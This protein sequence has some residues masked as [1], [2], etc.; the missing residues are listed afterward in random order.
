MDYTTIANVKAALKIEAAGD[1]ALLSSLV[2]RASRA[3]DRLITQSDQPDAVNY[4]EAAT[5]TDERLTGLVDANTILHCWPHKPL[6]TAVS[7]FSYRATP[8][9]SWVAVSPDYIE[10]YGQ[11]L[12]VYASATGKPFVKVTYAGGLATLAANLPA[13]LVEA[14]T[15]MAA[16]FYREDE[17][18][19]TDAIGVAELGV[20]VYT[21]AFPVRVLEMLRPYMRVIPW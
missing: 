14:A 15:V 5:V 18:G 17:G 21:K 6:V 8:L 7:A 1:D 20:L 10:I 9:E 2:T 11:H 12:M 19:L 13:D 16:R 4:L 3:L